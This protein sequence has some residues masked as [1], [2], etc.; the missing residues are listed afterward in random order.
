MLDRMTPPRTNWAGNHA[1]RAARLLEPGSVEEV[2]QLVRTS[3]RLK[4]LGSRHAFN[5]IA[6]TDGDQVSLARLPRRIDIDA[7]ART[8]TVDGAIR[9][10]ELAP[11]VHAAG[12]ALHNLASLPHI[13]VAGACQTAT[14]GSGDASG[15]LATAVRRVELIDGTG[16]VRTFDRAR[17][18]DTFPGVVVGLGALGI[19]IGL[20]LAI[21]P[22]YAVRQDVYEGLPFDALAERFDELT[23]AADSVSLFTTWSGDTIDQLWLKR[24]VD[25]A[26]PD[27]APAAMRFGA[28]RASRALHPVPSMDPASTTR[29]L[30]VPG[31]WHERLPHFRMDHTPS[32]GAE[33]QTELFVPRRH[34]PE[35]LAAVHAI[36]H[37]I[38]PL[39][40]T[41]EIRTVRADDLWLS[42][43]FERHAVGLHFTWRPDWQA[44]A[45]VLPELE[46]RLAPFEPRPHWAKLFTMSAGP[47]AASYSR[48]A[49]FRTLRAELDPDRRFDNAWLG[50]AL[51]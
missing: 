33:L 37:R 44:V 48:L 28:R 23:A 35:A 10:G 27:A 7:A 21:E 4:V 25:G 14:H 26:T 34:A 2:Q 47:I 36:R 30:G 51:G 24:R 19:V 8:V 17:D 40:Q 49:A 3:S 9:Y 22:T 32:A 1:Y 46:E 20:T 12:F 45:A 38:A 18:P 31:P 50:A 6:D 42:P 15:N 29:Q 5:A 11:V 41:S 43:A 16:N 39:V 13:S